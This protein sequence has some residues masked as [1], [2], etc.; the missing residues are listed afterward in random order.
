VTPGPPQPGEALRI[1]V[2]ARELSGR[3]TGTGRYL[4]NLLRAFTRDHGDTVVAYF[5]GTAPADAVLDHPR[6]IVRELPPTRPGL[7]WQ[8]RR[9][10]AAAR[11]DALDV[12][13]C[14]A[15][16]CPLA[17]DLPRV[18]TV[19]DLSF[20]ALPGDF[21]W[22]E[23]LRRRLTV[24]ASVR[25]SRRVLTVSEFSRRELVARFPEAAGRVV[26]VPHGADDDLVPPPDRAEARGR[27]GLDGPFVLTVG[28][29]FGRRRLPVLLRAIALLRR[30]HPRV[31]LEVV[32]DLRAHP[33]RNGPAL[34]AR[35]GLA[36]AVR[37]T[38][39]ASEAGLADRYAAAD[40]AV[41]LSEYEGFGL[42]ALEAM[43]RG[44]PVV[45]SDRPALDEVFAGAS[46]AVPLEDEAALASAL[47]RVLEDDA[48]RRDL[49]ARGHAL[50]ARH[51]WAEAA[52]LT[53]DAL[54]AAAREGP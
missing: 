2:D 48:L 33:P 28:T 40:A 49:V 54:A 13:F 29:V 23:G 37:Y 36:S 12:L 46:V 7:L 25:A 43:A 8:Q 16:T 9:L 24:A 4:R 3:P 27:L 39:F 5:N 15:Y 11:Q 31:R 51:S 26:A 1:G 53:R 22:R 50:A 20:F 21:T 42:P 35:L 41:F 17:L 32:G 10:P 6:V 18:T 19:H 38:G 14:P 44:V 34:A 47:A 45:V 52:R 30:R